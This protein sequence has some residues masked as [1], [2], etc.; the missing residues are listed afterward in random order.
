MSPLVLGLLG[1]TF[2]PSIAQ[3]LPASIRAPAN[4]FMNPLGELQ[5]ILKIG[6]AKAYGDATGDYRAFEQAI[7]SVELNRSYNTQTGDMLR[8]GLSQILPEPIANVVAPGNRNVAMLDEQDLVPFESAPNLQQ[9]AFR[10]LELQ[11]STEQYAPDQGVNYEPQISNFDY[12][13]RDYSGLPEYSVTVGPLEIDVPTVNMPTVD[14]PEFQMPAFEVPSFEMPSF[15]M[16]NGGSGFFIGPSIGGSD[17][18]FTMDAYKNGGKVKFAN[19][20]RA[21]RHELMKAKNGY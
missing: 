1:R 6:A 16:P 9:E 11:N 20:L 21:M 14:V 8:G 12:S 5:N 17:D 15:E 7:N 3:D 4:F 18:V 13:L 2:G 19:N 10:Q